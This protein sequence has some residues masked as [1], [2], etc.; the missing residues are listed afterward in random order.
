MCF[1]MNTTR[2]AENSVLPKRT[3]VEHTILIVLFLMTLF[4]AAWLGLAG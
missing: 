1:R 4:A 3:V 2:P